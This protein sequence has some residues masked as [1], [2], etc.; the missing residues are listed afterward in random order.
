MDVSSMKRADWRKLFE[1]LVMEMSKR[2]GGGGGG[3]CGCG[4]H[5]GHGGGGMMMPMQTISYDLPPGG[6]GMPH[7]YGGPEY[8]RRSRRDSDFDVRSEVDR[9]W[10]PLL[11]DVRRQPLGGGSYSSSYS[12]RREN[13]DDFLNWG[14]QS[15]PLP[16]ASTRDAGD[17]LRFAGAG[18]PPP[19]SSLPS[20]DLPSR[21]ADAFLRFG[22][23]APTGGGGSSLA[24]DFIRSGGGGGGGGG[25]AADAFIR[26]GGG[27]GGGGSLSNDA[28]AFLAGR[29]A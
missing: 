16:S 25:S 6:Y 5:G 29:W 2:K 9:I 11:R 14:R 15:V 22:E 18:A 24:D 8:G 10:D 19:S 27:G 12:S 23:G 20:R 28:N 17:F 26:S 21:D 4:G 13:A 1:R 3:G 7:G